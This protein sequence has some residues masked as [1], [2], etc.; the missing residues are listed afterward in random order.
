MKEI[1][2]FDHFTMLH[3]TIFLGI[4]LDKVNILVL[5]ISEKVSIHFKAVNVEVIRFREGLMNTFID[6]H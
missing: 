5:E 2:D 6:F 3:F 1:N 4:E